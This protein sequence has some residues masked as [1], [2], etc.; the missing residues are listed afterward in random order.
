[1]EINELI[2]SQ[3]QFFK[4]LQVLCKK[5][6]VCI[7]GCGCCDSPVVYFSDGT[8]FGNLYVDADGIEVTTEKGK[9]EW[10][11]K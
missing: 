7:S 6:N 2:F 10:E 11:N 8:E 9:V 3:R 5:W 4:E 1:M